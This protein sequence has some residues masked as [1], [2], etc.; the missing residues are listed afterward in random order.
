M[1]APLFRLGVH[2]LSLRL[3]VETACRPRVT[4]ILRFPTNRSVSEL[5]TKIS[6]GDHHSRA[7]SSLNDRRRDDHHSRA[8]S[9]LNDCRRDDH[10]SRALS[11][12]ND[13]RDNAASPSH[14]RDGI[15]PATYDLVYVAAQLGSY[16]RPVKL[17]CQLMCGIFLATSI[18]ALTY[19]SA[20]R[21][22]GEVVS[23]VTSYEFAAM[24]G[25]MVSL[26]ALA[27]LVAARVVVRVYYCEAENEFKF[28]TNA[29]HPGMRH[30]RVRAG[31]MEPASRYAITGIL[32]GNYRVNR[33]SFYI[34]PENFRFPIYY[35][36]LLGIQ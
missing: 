10:H 1:S 16:L 18:P 9:S 31:G 29:W 26:T 35:N 8:L 33:Q 14:A 5:P 19:D 36:R 27:T 2:S 7:L 12:L 4:N 11:S 23:G 32:F 17:S 22:L 28:V 24:A 13:R 6:P 34:V 15:D 30:T 25:G 21:D 3:A 20:A